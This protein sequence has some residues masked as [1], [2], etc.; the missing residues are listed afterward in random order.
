MPPVGRIT[1]PGE[2]CDGWI[3]VEA[4]VVGR[5]GLQ[6]EVS[7]EPNEDDVIEHAACLEGRRTA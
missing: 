2:G 1:C 6:L 5:R 3:G 7:V 4:R